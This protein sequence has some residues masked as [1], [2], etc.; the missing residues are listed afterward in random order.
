MS[1]EEENQVRGIQHLSTT[2]KERGL[3]AGD[4]FNSQVDL[5]KRLKDKSGGKKKKNLITY[6]NH[7]KV[8]NAQSI[9]QLFKYYT[10]ILVLYL[11]ILIG[12][13]IRSNLNYI[14]RQSE[15]S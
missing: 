2:V 15:F 3:S 12:Y 7:N 14:L 4:S 9:L 5:S 6:N 8:A 10:V 13:C 1:V 11:V